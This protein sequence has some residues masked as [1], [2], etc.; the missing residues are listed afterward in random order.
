MSGVDLLLEGNMGTTGN[1]S[2]R[3]DGRTGQ[4]RAGLRIDTPL[5]R[6]RERND[7]RVA[8]INYQRARRDYALFEDRVSQSLRNTLRISELSR[9]NFE[10][11]RAALQVALAQ[12][13]LAR[14]RLEEPPRPGQVAQ[15]GATTA[16]D[17]VS[18]L[19][20]LLDAEN[21]FLGLWVGHHVLRMVLDYELGTMAVDSDGRWIE[22]GPF[23]ADAIKKRLGPGL[24]NTRA[25][26]SERIASNRGRQPSISVQ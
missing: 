10:L 6:L 4:L 1:D 5:D 2:T 9:M 14:L 12:V 20:D 23:T 24:A 22:P 18:A 3:L 25:A 17:L 7:Y 26:A 16:R 21:E 13:D 15:I 11:R 19:S 8:Q